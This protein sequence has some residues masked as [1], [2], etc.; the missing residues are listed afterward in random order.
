LVVK[1]KYLAEEKEDRKEIRKEETELKWEVEGAQLEPHSSQSSGQDQ[2]GHSSGHPTPT[3][4]THR[5]ANI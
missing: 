4:S 2:P 3:W 1:G 5:I